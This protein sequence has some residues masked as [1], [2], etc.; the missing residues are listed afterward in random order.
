MSNIQEI[1]SAI[2]KLS[3]EDLAALRHWFA[4][5]DARQWDGE[6]EDDVK[7]GRLDSLA[8]EALSDLREGRC[9]DL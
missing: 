5:F 9:R 6:F 1:E 3:H 2:Q 4:E 8:A 7:S